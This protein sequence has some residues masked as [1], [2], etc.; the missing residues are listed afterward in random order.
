MHV[1]P[2][3]LSSAQVYGRLSS[4]PLAGV[5]IAG[6][7]GDQQAALFGQMCFDI[8]SAK[9]TYGTG[10]F[11][12][13]NT[14][15]KPCLSSSGLLTTV[16]Y[17]IGANQPVVYALEGSVASAGSAVNWLKNQLKLISEASETGALA[18]SVPNTGN[19]YFVPAFSGNNPIFGD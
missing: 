6:C 9:N 18:T 16:A 7:L 17:Q 3:I 10:C 19:V 4:G 13:M 8:G 5:Q 2:K 12:L 11:M 14:G 1:L 15:E